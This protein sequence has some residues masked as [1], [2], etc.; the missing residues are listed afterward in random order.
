MCPIYLLNV[1]AHLRK[2]ITSFKHFGRCFS[3]SMW[4]A[5]KNHIFDEIRIQ[6]SKL[7]LTA[8]GSH[9]CSQ[10]LG[11]VLHRLVDVFLWHLFPDGLQGDF[12]LINRFGLR[13]EFMVLFEHGSPDVTVQ[14]VQIWRIWGR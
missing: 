14:W 1:V 5:V 8:D 11:D 9:T 12:Q 4:V 2:I 6:T 7:T 3:G 13:L 10:A